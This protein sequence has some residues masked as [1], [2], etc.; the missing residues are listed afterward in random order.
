MYAMMQV[1]VC[2]RVTWTCICWILKHRRQMKLGWTGHK[3][4]AF[5]TQSKA[6]DPSLAS[7]LHCCFLAT[8]WICPLGT[9]VRGI[10]RQVWD[11]GQW[12]K[13]LSTPAI[14][15]PHVHEYL[16]KGTVYL[17]LG[18][19]VKIPMLARCCCFCADY[20]DVEMAF[21]FFLTEVFLFPQWW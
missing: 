16:V 8:L 21:T 20:S 10:I 9:S 13:Y 15:W 2:L 17:I 19:D 1:F 7:S 5:P 6:R 14:A 3:E 18:A 4:K 11:Q 12:P